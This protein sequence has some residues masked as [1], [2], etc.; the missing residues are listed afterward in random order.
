M[1]VPAEQGRWKGLKAVS[2]QA[3]SSLRAVGCS[4][5][6]AEASV[7]ASHGHARQ[8][9]PL[10]ELSVKKLGLKAELSSSSVAAQW[11]GTLG[12]LV[13]DGAQ[14]AWEEIVAPLDLQV[15]VHMKRG[16]YVPLSQAYCRSTCTQNAGSGYFLCRRVHKTCMQLLCCFADVVCAGPWVCCEVAVLG[17]QAAEAYSKRVEEGARLCADRGRHQHS[18]AA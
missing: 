2:V 14:G 13:R 16:G 3:A 18:R 1:I 8:E 15:A 9:V 7:L 10:A 4:V 6:V 12:L 17:M 11:A 5:E